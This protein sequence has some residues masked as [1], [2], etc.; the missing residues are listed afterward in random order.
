MGEFLTKAALVT[1]GGTYAVLPYVDQGG[2]DTYG[3]LTGT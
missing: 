3:W 2:V 1:F